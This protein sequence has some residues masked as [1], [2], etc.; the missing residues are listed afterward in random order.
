MRDVLSA[1]T[2]LNPRIESHHMKSR[3]HVSSEAGDIDFL[4]LEMAGC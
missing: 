2:T 4:A 1:E 3:D